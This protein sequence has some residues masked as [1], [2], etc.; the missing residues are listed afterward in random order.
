MSP[1][2]TVSQHANP[3]MCPVSRAYDGCCIKFNLMNKTMYK[4]KI[5]LE[6]MYL[7]FK[8]LIDC[9]DDGPG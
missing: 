1:S 8:A 4:I 9:N 3:P 2:C 5:V 6:G 7:A